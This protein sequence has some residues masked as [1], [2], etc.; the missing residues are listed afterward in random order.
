M[1][2]LLRTATLLLL[3]LTP[4][5]ALAAPPE[6]VQPRVKVELL[7]DSE[8]LVPGGTA[9]IG[10]RFTLDEHWHLY[11]RHAGDAG[12][13]TELGFHGPDGFHF[14]PVQWPVPT[15]FPT[16]TG[17]VGYGYEGKVLLAAEVTVPPDALEGDEVT[18]TR[19][20]KPVAVLVHPDLLR[21]RRIEP[22]V[23][24][25]QSRVSD[26]IDVGRSR[27]VRAAPS[28]TA[29]DADAWVREQRADRSA[30]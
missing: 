6:A 5:A 7:A 18:L 24:E 13:P 9:R 21:A 25:L 22:E 8:A 3:L 27:P 16:E 28:L 15:R 4:P 2:P 17:L 20:G 23:A 10:L 1:T 26:L 19:H 29:H 30:R 12:L 11:W 14:G